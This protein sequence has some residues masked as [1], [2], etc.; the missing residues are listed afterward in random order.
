MSKSTI[1]TTAPEAIVL[2]EIDDLTTQLTVSLRTSVDLALRIGLR[3]LYLYRTTGPEDGGFRAALERMA[4]NR[5]PRPTAYRWINATSMVLAR[6]QQIT[7]DNGQY[8]P[9]DLT[10]P[11]P[12]TPAWKAAEK[13]LASHAQGTSIRRL[14]LGSAET[15]EDSRLDHLISHEEAGD[16]H[17]AQILDQVSAGELT[18]VQA[19][20][21][22]GGKIT[23]EKNRHDP[24]YLD[25]D[26]RTGQPVGLFP[27][28]LITITNTFARWEQLDE[29]ARRAARAA[30]KEVVSKLPKDLR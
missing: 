12:G 24:V 4:C 20:R 11:E 10:V 7:L 28:S 9:A 23:K 2:T 6:Q 1:K 15:S 26:G 13:A 8:N 22:L 5:I 21:A 17:A 19:I 16:K 14:T 25:L 3:L 29:A 27:R 18:L 30:W